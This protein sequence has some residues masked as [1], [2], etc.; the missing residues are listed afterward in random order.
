M[1][2]KKPAQIKKTRKPDYNSNYVK[3]FQIQIIHRNFKVNLKSGYCCNFYEVKPK[4]YLSSFQT[5][6]CKFILN[7]F[8]F[9]QTKKTGNFGSLKTFFRDNKIIFLI[10]NRYESKSWIFCNRSNGNPPV[11]FFFGQQ[12]RQLSYEILLPEKILRA[13]DRLNNDQAVHV[14]HFPCYGWSCVFRD[15]L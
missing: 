9:K 13:A 2:N 7:I 14:Y 6:F 8:F 3:Y 4:I 1:I 10:L 11:C 15:Y 5:K 12:L